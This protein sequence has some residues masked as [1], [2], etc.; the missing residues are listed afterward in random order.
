MLSEE[1]VGVEWASGMCSEWKWQA[2]WF[3]FAPY[4]SRYLLSR[5]PRHCW[6]TAMDPQTSGCLWKWGIFHIRYPMSPYEPYI[7]I[8][9]MFNLHNGATSKATNIPRFPAPDDP[10]GRCQ[11]WNP[12]AKVN[13]RSGLRRLVASTCL[14]PQKNRIPGTSW[15]CWRK[16]VSPCPVFF[17]GWDTFA[18]VCVGLDGFI[19]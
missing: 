1:L 5:P 4:M 8:L 6:F 3:H 10:D 15:R 9:K 16:C 11:Y 17:S 2:R 12:W 14:E 18:I 13:S 7:N 19:I